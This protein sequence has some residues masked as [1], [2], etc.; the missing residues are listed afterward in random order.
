MIPNSRSNVWPRS[1]KRFM[2]DFMYGRGL[3]ML[4][5]NM[6]RQRSFSTTFME[7]G[8]HSGK[9]GR[10]EQINLMGTRKD[11][12]PLK[13]VPLLR[14]TDVN[15]VAKR[16]LVS[17]SFE[18]LPTFD[19]H[20]VA[21]PR[22][23]LVQQGFAFTENV[24]WWGA[25]RA[26]SERRQER[27]QQYSALADFWAGVPYSAS[28]AQADLSG[29]GCVLEGLGRGQP[30]AQPDEPTAALAAAAAKS[31]LSRR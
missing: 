23:T 20:H 8:D 28:A 12:D 2:I 1:W 26:L 10:K 6:K 22:D 13:T 11:V 21:R 31:R 4:Y 24:R 14:T 9:D 17:P 27:R 5:P 25:R 29:G 7:R 19:V 16:L 18:E 3:V 30:S 15:E